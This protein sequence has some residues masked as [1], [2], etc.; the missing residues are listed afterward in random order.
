MSKI[1]YKNKLTGNYGVLEGKVLS[2]Q[3]SSFQLRLIKAVGGMVEL[4]Y[5]QENVTA[6]NLVQVSH[7]EVQKALLGF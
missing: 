3:S 4:S 1:F 6:K 2:S 7:D 5:Q